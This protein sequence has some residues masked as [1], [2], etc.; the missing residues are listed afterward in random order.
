MLYFDRYFQQ[1]Q[2]LRNNHTPRTHSSSYNHL[3]KYLVQVVKKRECL[4]HITHHV[5]ARSYQEFQEQ[6][7][8]TQFSLC[9]RAYTLVTFALVMF[10][11]DW[12]CG[13]RFHLH[14]HCHPTCHYLSGAWNSVDSFSQQIP[15]SV[16][17][18]MV[19]GEA[20]ISY[21]TVCHRQD[22]LDMVDEMMILP[23]PGYLKPTNIGGITS[24]I[25]YR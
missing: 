11:N 18:S 17:L 21:Y 24:L 22:C 2:V 9:C 10:L 25:Q 3:H 14:W 7:H 19:V 23:T 6:W 13:N 4:R 8:C 16:L 1:H 20:V 15:Q 12:C 5:I